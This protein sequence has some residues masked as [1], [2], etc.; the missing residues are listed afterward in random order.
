M[1]ITVDRISALIEE[2]DL[3][4]RELAEYAGCSKSA[5]Q[6]YITGERDIPTSVI[7]GLAKAFHVHPAFLFGWVD[8]KNYKLQGKPTETSELSAKKKEFIQ[9]V[10]EMSD[11][12]LERLE[13]ILALVESTD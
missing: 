1:N 5:M 13:K 8:D 3:T 11:A 9:R 4:V 12:Q 7:N 2:T 10:S 6:R